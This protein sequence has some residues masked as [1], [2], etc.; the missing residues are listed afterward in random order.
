MQNKIIMVDKNL[1]PA[2]EEIG[3]D[4][5]FDYFPDHEIE[6][7]E[8][9]THYHLELNR[10][11]FLYCEN[12]EKG[13]RD[14][15]IDKNEVRYFHILGQKSFFCLLESW[16]PFGWSKFITETQ[17]LPEKLSLIHL[18]DHTDLMSPKISITNNRWTDML[19]RK[20]V[21][22]SEPDSIRMAIESGAITV[23]S[24]MTP[25]IHHIRNVDV[26]HLMQNVDTVVQCLEKDKHPDTLIDP[27][28]KRISINFLENSYNKSMK[29][30]I[31]LK[32]SHL[33]EIIKNIKPEAEI[34]L[35]ID[36]DYFNN[37]YNGSTDWANYSLKYNLSLDEQKI[38]MRIFCQKILDA[39]LVSRIKH[40]SI[41]V[42]PSFYPAEFWKEGTIFLLS[43]LDSIGL[44]VSDLMKQLNL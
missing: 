1:L 36:M 42:S 15:G 18:D 23:G 21:S 13:L 30:N 14:F 16:I 8:T 33:S 28:Q 32:T 25:L 7:T 34:F 40:V 26:F 39:G 24:M 38:V 6:I 10:S 11:D 31:Y 3:M 20:S 12:V 44:E 37:R 43:E 41:G 27:S 4:V 5:I 9:P 19:T 35:H 22:F 2:N 29:S 17:Y